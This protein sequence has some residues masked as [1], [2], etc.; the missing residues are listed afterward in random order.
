MPNVRVDTP[1]GPLILREA[2]DA[3]TQLRWGADESMSS[4]SPILA[5]ACAQIEAYF[6]GLLRRFDVPLRPSGSAFDLSVWRLLQEIP[7]GETKTYGALARTLGTSA[8]AV[9]GACSRN[10]IP[11]II[12]CH[13]VTGAGGHLGGYSGGRGLETKRALLRLETPRGVAPPS[14][15]PRPP[16]DERSLT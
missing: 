11:V 9:G 13:R 10:P 1:V 16:I 15:R 7:Y 4:V 2:G 3:V 8:R 14:R 5:A 12:P 6:Q